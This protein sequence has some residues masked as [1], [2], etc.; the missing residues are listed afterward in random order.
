MQA[1]EKPTKWLFWNRVKANRSKGESFRT[2][3]YTSRHIHLLSQQR[4]S[5]IRWT[6]RWGAVRAFLIGVGCTG[7]LMYLAQATHQWFGLDQEPKALELNTDSSEA[8][9]GYWATLI[10]LSSF[11]TVLELALLYW[12]IFNTGVCLAYQ[13]G[14]QLHDDQLGNSDFLATSVIQDAMELGYPITKIRSID[15][16]RETNWLVRYL[17]T[18]LYKGKTAI[19][20]IGIK[21]IL[22]R[23]L[24]RAGISLFLG[25]LDVPI[26]AL[27]NLL[28]ATKNLDGIRIGL[29]FPSLVCY[30]FNEHIGTCCMSLVTRQQVLRAIGVTITQNGSTG[31]GVRC[32]LENAWVVCGGDSMEVER[33][34]DSGLFLEVLQ[35]QTQ[36]EQRIVIIALACA[37]IGDGRIQIA[38]SLYL[39]NILDK[40]DIGSSDVRVRLFRK[41]AFRLY[42]GEQLDLTEFIRILF[43][44][45]T[46]SDVSASS[47]WGLVPARIRTF[48]QRRLGSCF[49]S[50]CGSICLA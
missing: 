9:F 13:A 31:P 16:L 25:W 45:L 28:V 15:P 6:C 10:A 17:L 32:L 37:L 35:S 46:P 23:V 24:S 34:D 42:Q 33:L 38:E 39:R 11:F 40:C 50:K 47:R 29:A 22:K 12:D 41:F 44:D 36:Q 21:F 2:F 5:R 30:A 14:V 18:L 3:P 1:V 49:Y 43:H 27:M 26:I 48:F 19:L 8:T 20:T 7:L 4:A